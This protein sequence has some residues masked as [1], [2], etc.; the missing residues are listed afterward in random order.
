MFLAISGDRKAARNLV[1][2][3]DGVKRRCNNCR[4]RVVCPLPT[5]SAADMRKAGRAH[6]LEDRAA[7]PVEGG[8]V[9]A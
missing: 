8:R 4:V 1:Q 2:Q 6:R 9:V 5:G 7:F 3:A